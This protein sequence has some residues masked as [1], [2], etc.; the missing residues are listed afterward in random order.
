MDER[1]LVTISERELLGFRLDTVEEE[2]G[3]KLW[4]SNS[5]VRSAYFGFDVSEFSRK[6]HAEEW[7]RRRVQRQGVKYF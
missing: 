6:R 3:I 7:E 5:D 4:A 2:R 1:T